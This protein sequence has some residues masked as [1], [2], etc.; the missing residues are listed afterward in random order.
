MTPKEKVAFAS[1]IA[2]IGLVVTK[3][4]VAVWTNSLGILSEAL[5]SSIDLIAAFVTLAAVRMA[6]RPADADHHYGHEKVESL[7][8]LFETALLF[9][10]CGWIVYEAVHRLI[11]P[12]EVD[13]TYIA[14]GVMVFSIIVDFTR[15]RALHKMAK[16][17]KSQALEADAIHFSTDLFSSVVVIIGI[18][19]TMMGY[20]TFDVIAALG[21]AAITAVIGYRLWKRSIHTLMD[22]APEGISELVANE[23]MRIREIRGVDQVRVRETGPKVYI[24]CTVFIDK[25]V[26]LEQA[27]RV[28]DEFTRRIRKRV[29]NAEIMVNAEPFCVEPTDLVD[30]IRAEAADFEEIK[31][32]H[33]I[34]V[35]E[36]DNDIGEDL[37]VDFHLEL[38]GD[39]SLDIAHAIATRLENRIKTLDQ[40]ITLVT[41]HIEPADCHSCGL[42]SVRVGEEGIAHS[43]K[44][45]VGTFPEIEEMTRISV[46]KKEGK[47]RVGMC[48]SFGRTNSVKEAHD[49]AEKLEGVIRA[50][51][52][53]VDVVSI[54][55]EP[56]H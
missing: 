10:T 48:C 13:V 22:G 52:P 44:Q 42:K 40:R 34:N 37:E 47:I 19:F 29:D 28:T 8:S 26:P 49:V 4:I 20:K 18:L 43:I 41:T 33:N 38:D 17:Y 21:V 30:K 7:S 12:V 54:H 1:V 9:V 31:T 53:E 3:I 16:R 11:S 36:F 45:L 15:S 51:H 14:I 32:V 6:E 27:H 56:G 5:H 55:M 35:S 50:K 46:Q 25:V 24:D 2:A 39:L 23:A